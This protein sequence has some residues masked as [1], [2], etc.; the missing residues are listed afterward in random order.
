MSVG[1]TSGIATKVLGEKGEEGNVIFKI[2]V[3]EQ[4]HFLTLKTILRSVTASENSNEFRHGFEF[5]D[6]TVHERLVL[7][8]FV[9]QILAEVND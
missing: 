2:N 5:V 1:G 6:M 9:N 3:A 8:A 4:E 7:S